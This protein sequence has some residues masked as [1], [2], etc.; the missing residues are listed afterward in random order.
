MKIEITIA[1][2][3]IKKLLRDHLNEKF[4]NILI[5]EKDIRIEVK[6]KQNYSSEWERAD[7]RATIKR[8]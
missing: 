5:E 6:S 7:F 4:G 8:F 1:E 3:E 2:E